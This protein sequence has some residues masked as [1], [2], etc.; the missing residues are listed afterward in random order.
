M[1]YLTSFVAGRF[2]EMTQS[3]D[4]VPLHYNFPASK[5]DDVLRY[6]GETPRIM[7]VF[8]EFTWM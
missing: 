6:F 8:R 4:G 7:Q 5:R 2:E 1:T 3:A